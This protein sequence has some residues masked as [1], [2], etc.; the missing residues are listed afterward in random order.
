MDKL[1]TFADRLVDY[2]NGA[3][4][5]LKAQLPDFVQQ[6]VAYET[7][8]VGW[9]Y[10]MA[11]IVLAILLIMQLC[12]FV[13][14]ILGDAAENVV[15]IF[16]GVGIA[17]TIALFVFIDNYSAVKKLEIAPKVYMIEAAKSLVVGK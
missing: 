4:V 17:G 11:L 13:R 1:N 3:E 10:E 14:I 15:G 6:F 16:F 8:K 9:Y 12:V 2:L 5:F 7:W